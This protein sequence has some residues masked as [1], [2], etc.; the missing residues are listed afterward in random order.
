MEITFPVSGS[1]TRR[2]SLAIENNIADWIQ[3]K[4]LRNCAV[5]ALAAFTIVRGGEIYRT[6]E[7]SALQDRIIDEILAVVERKKLTLPENDQRRK[8]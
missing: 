3:E 5:N 7:V 4:F 6:P 2:V 8:I 1:D